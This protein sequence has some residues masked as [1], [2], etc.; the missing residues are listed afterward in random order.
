VSEAKTSDNKKV[1]LKSL[2]EEK[3]SKIEENVI[4]DFVNE[5]RIIFKSIIL[6]AGRVIK[7][8]HC[9]HFS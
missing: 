5:V 2:I 6:Y 7:K 9:F 4:K 1:A 8:N 3:S